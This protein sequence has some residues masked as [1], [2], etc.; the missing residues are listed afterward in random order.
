MN[1]VILAIMGAM[2]ALVVAVGVLIVVV[3]ATG[4]GSGGGTG[5]GQSASAETP[6]G[7]AGGPSGQL[8]L[9]GPE[10]ITLDPHIAQD[11]SSAVY[12]VEIFGGL[13]TLDQQLNVQPDLV[14][15][16]PTVENGGKAVNADG[17]ATY[18]F[19][20]RPNVTFQDHKP[21]TADIVKCSLERAANPATQSLV[22]EFFLGDIVGVKDVVDGNATDISGV[23]VV[24]PSTVAITIQRDIASF[25]YKLTYPTSFVVDPSQVGGTCGGRD[26]GNGDSNW[27]RRP[28]GTGPYQLDQWRLGEEIRLLANDH[29]QLGVAH[30]KSVRVLLAGG[31]ITAYE[32]GDIDLTGV[33][34]DDIER[35]KDPADPLNK[36]YHTGTQLSV[37]YIGFN[38]K[39]PPFDDPKVRQA[40]AMAVDRNKIATAVFHDALPVADKIIM[41]GMPAYNE[42]I[43]GPA[44]DPVRAKQLLEESTYGGPED[45]P[46]ITF[47]ESGTGA[48]GGAD[49]SAIVE[50][51]RTNLG[52]TVQIQQAE[53]ATF[54]QDVADGRYQ[55]FHLGWIMDY[56][57]EEDLLNIHFDSES[58]NN[59]TFYKNTQVDDLLRRAQIEPDKA[60]RN[61]LYQQAEQIILNDVPWMPLFF[62]RYHQ[63]IKPYVQNYQVAGTIVPRLR[64]VT[65]TPH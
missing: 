1:R 34:L 58:P 24:D 36:D 31:G 49:T 55:A 45:L 22:S 15:E 12:I 39:D 53:S 29:Y 57:D 64:F 9:S 44:F 42:D 63:L 30:V 3:V 50:M 23:K 47:A 8:C 13:L 7:A 19:H 27:T 2:A 43:K 18:T 40:F 33:G 21:V 60:T 5:C 37:D 10:P 28:N 11:A 62:S 14:S 65:L 20:L 32:K 4:G 52:V 6:S 48:T 16:I 46:E 51:W 41:P 26:Y 59:D 61:Q 56:P 35:V 38:T 17:T 54:F 25:L